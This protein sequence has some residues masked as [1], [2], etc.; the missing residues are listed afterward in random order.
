MI[1]AIDYD[2]F[3]Y[4]TYEAY[5]TWEGSWEIIDGVAYAMSPATYLK[6]SKNRLQYRQR[7]RWSF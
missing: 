3:P 1:E 6:A 5:K 4:Y 7:D 2:S